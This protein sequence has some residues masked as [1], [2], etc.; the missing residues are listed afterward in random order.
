MLQGDISNLQRYF[1]Q[2]MDII[3][4][5]QR[6]FFYNLLAKCPCVATINVIHIIIIYRML[7]IYYYHA[8]GTQCSWSRL[9]ARTLPAR[10]RTPRGRIF[11]WEDVRTY[12]HVKR[13]SLARFTSEAQLQAGLR[14]RKPQRWSSLLTSCG[15]WVWM[16]WGFGN[17]L[18]LCE[19]VFFF[20]TMPQGRSYPQ[21]SLFY[22]IIT[23]IMKTQF[24]LGA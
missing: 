10:V 21:S 3:I 8:S 23:L 9:C 2:S 14:Q 18:D 6:C 22:I 5:L 4:G 17:F 7:Y 11:S 1:F 15:P 13:N 20:N 24:F 19:K 16:G 12:V